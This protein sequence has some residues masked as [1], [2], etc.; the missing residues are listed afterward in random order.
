MQQETREVPLMH[1]L[2]FVIIIS[3]VTQLASAIMAMSL[4]RITRKWVA[5]T[6]IAVAVT[7]MMLR[8]VESLLMLLGGEA[9]TRSLIV[10]E[11]VGLATSIFMLAGIVLIRPIFLAITRTDD[12]LRE[13][14][15]KLSGLSE[16]QSLLLAHTRDV[17]Y[18]QDPAGIITYVSPAV[19]HI[20]GYTQAEWLEHYASYYTEIP[21]HD[22]LGRVRVLQTGQADPTFRIEVMHKNG[23]KV[24]LE[25]NRQPYVVSGK[26]AGFIGVARDVTRRVNLEQ[27]REKL[28][29]ERQNALTQ[30]KTLKGLLPICSVC[31]KVR[32]DRGYW[33][34][35]D[36]YV[37]KH[38]GA[39]FT[40][41][42]CP[43]CAK[44]L[45]PGYFEEETP[46]Q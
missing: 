30:I 29:V 37:S 34:Q 45:Y 22:V 11:V 40:H 4:I 35:I 18:R 33:N 15:A 3:V 19:E 1:P 43:D 5:W 24:W 36:A 21:E 31:K 20:T 42:L 8:R 27:E 32:D 2:G 12:E 16:E 46:S 17:V 38:S 10:F 25:V 7:L 44:Q 14:N 13:A 26:V 28:L 41:G 6:L 9:V 39:E 23:H